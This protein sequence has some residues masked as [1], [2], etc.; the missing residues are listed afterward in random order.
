VREAI[1]EAD[2][3]I[4]PEMIEAV[5]FPNEFQKDQELFYKEMGRI[6][7]KLPC[8]RGGAQG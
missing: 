4:D 8:A 5:P 1:E 2:I 3:N 7:P 6:L